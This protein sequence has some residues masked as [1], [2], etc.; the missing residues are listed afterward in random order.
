MGALVWNILA[1][2]YSVAET[3]FNRGPQAINSLA[4]AYYVWYCPGSVL[5][6]WVMERYGLR[7]SLLWGFASQVVMA[8]LSVIG[9]TMEPPHV[10]FFIL[11]LGQVIGSFGQPLFLNNVTRVA[12]D[13]FPINERDMAVTISVVARSVGV[14]LISFVAPLV[15]QEP[16]QVG[17]LYYWQLPVWLIILGVAYWVVQDRP[18]QPPSASAAM[19][20]KVREEAEA[21]P[22][23][24]GTGR[25]WR[26]LQIMWADSSAL[27]R[28]TNFMLLTISFSLLTGLGWTFL[29]IVGQLLEPCG[30]SNLLAGIAN[31]VFMG[32]NAIGC[33]AAAPV[34]E[35]TRAYLTLQRA[36]SWGTFLM[37]IVVLGTAKPGN[38]AAVLGAW[39]ALGFTMGPLTPISFEH[40]VEMTYPIP[41]NSSNTILNMVSNLVGFFQT[42]G[43]TPLLTFPVSAQCLSVLTPAAAYM[44]FTAALGLGAAMFIWKD[45]R[46][47]K[48]EGVVAGDP[49]MDEAGYSAKVK[50][51][52]LPADS[53]A[54]PEA[55]ASTPLLQ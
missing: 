48:A 52:A 30:Y 22:L 21:E 4:N 44:M 49:W 13:W 36:F 14:M 12:G 54:P 43:I 32:A 55:N 37:C 25:N 38:P 28:H 27:L 39:A 40:A 8:T 51:G 35:T 47:Q 42:V 9:C 24:E 26:A 16:G 18:P 45:Y 15:V 34:V 17:L 10:A 31:A 33:F 3:R 41:P 29:T 6:L 1:P 5:A 50:P 7:V 20:W 53:S 23:P 19:Q 46:R 2:V 11:W